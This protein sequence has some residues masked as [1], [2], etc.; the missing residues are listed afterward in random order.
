MKKQKPETR[1]IF[2]AELINE[3]KE[4]RKPIRFTASVTILGSSDWLTF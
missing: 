4:K 3:L 2:D 1:N